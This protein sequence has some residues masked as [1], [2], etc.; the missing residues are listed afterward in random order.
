MCKLATQYTDVFIDS[1]IKQSLCGCE[2]KIWWKIQSRWNSIVS[3]CFFIHFRFL[4]IGFFL[5]LKICWKVAGNSSI[6]IPDIIQFCWAD[7]KGQDKKNCRYKWNEKDLGMNKM[8]IGHQQNSQAGPASLPLPSVP[9]IVSVSPHQ[10]RH[11]SQQSVCLL[12]PPWGSCCVRLKASF[13]KQI[14][15]VV[16]GWQPTAHTQK[17]SLCS[18][19]VILSEVWELKSQLD[20]F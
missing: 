6:D 12:L 14:F 11:K 16:G 3:E 20:P 5:S 4:K 7:V 10:H 19:S 2:K 13:P 17:L 8:S 1:E 15:P 9:I 18:S